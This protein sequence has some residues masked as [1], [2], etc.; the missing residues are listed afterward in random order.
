MINLTLK[1][2]SYVIRGNHYENENVTLTGKDVFNFDWQKGL[3][4]KLYRISHKN[5]TK[6]QNDV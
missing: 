1:L 3:Y 5:K 2:S 4:T 6:N